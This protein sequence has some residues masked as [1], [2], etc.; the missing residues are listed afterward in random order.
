LKLNYGQPNAVHHITVDAVT[1][2]AR[3]LWTGAE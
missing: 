2:E 3:N 1:E